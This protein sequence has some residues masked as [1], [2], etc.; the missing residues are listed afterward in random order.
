[1]TSRAS[2]GAPDGEPESP[3]V[4]PEGGGLPKLRDGRVERLAVRK[5]RPVRYDGRLQEGPDN[6]RIVGPIE[7]ERGIDDRQQHL[8]LQPGG[9][10]RALGARGY[11]RLAFETRLRE[12]AIEGVNAAGVHHQ[13]VGAQDL[14]DA[15]IEEG[16][17]RHRSDD[18]NAVLEISDQLGV[19]ARE[20]HLVDRNIHG[21]RGQ[22]RYAVDQNALLASAAIRVEHVDGGAG[23]DIRDRADTPDFEPTNVLFAADVST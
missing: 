19:A 22:L 17:Q 13:L 9:H 5:E 21:H 18:G 14:V 1:M 23:G 12:L 2:E 7:A 20:D 10:A 16:C 6:Q 11:P 15:G 3:A 4:L 8:Q